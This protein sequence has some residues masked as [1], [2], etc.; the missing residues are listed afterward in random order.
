MDADNRLEVIS[1]DP[2]DE[3]TLRT[4]DLVYLLTCRFSKEEPDQT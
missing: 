2:T 1:I 4:Y 3:E